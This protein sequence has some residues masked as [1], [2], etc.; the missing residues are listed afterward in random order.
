M[1]VQAPVDQAMN[2]YPILDEI[3]WHES[4]MVTF[5]LFEQFLSGSAAT[6]PYYNTTAS[7][8]VGHFSSITQHNMSVMS[9]GESSTP[10]PTRKIFSP[11]SGE[12]FT[13]ARE[14]VSPE[15]SYIPPHE[16]TG[17]MRS[18][19][20]QHRVVHAC[21]E[22]RNKKKKCSG[23]QPLCL[24]CKKAG[25]VCTWTPIKTSKNRPCHNYGVAKLCRPQS[26]TRERKSMTRQ[27]LIGDI[28]A[29]KPTYP[30]KLQDIQGAATSAFA[31]QKPQ[32]VSS[33]FGVGFPVEI[34]SRRMRTVDFNWSD[35]G[36]SDLNQEYIPLPLTPGR[37][38]YCGDVLSRVHPLHTHQRLLHEDIYPRALAGR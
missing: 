17:P 33:S 2:L 3:S 11:V 18:K 32:T 23:E 12:S 1:P 27:L 4:L 36:P 24:S 21:D 5:Q 28:A 25:R 6:A 31:I 35:L 34:S 19:R 15:G 10:S 29:P 30:I 38:P 7:L 14:T 37:P 20:A 9:P 22:C 16:L 26:Y 8:P 13:T